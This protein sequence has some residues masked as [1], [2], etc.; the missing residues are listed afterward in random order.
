MK[1]ARRYSLTIF[2]PQYDPKAPVLLG[3][4]FYLGLGIL[5]AHLLALGT[6]AEDKGKIKEW[7]NGAIYEHL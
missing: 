1:V 6:P 2:S 3:V 7:L 4:F 5:L